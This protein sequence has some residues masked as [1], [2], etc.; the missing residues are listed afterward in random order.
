MPAWCDVAWHEE[1]VA[2]FP[3]DSM[4]KSVLFLLYDV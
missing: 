2:L 4:A 3:Y 1:K